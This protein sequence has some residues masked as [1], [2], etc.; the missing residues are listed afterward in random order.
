MKQETPKVAPSET[1]LPKWDGPLYAANTSHHRRYDEWF[2]EGTPLE[3]SWRVLDLGCGSGDFTRV[4]ADLV[5]RGHVVGI[6]PQRSLLDEAEHRAGP[7]QSFAQGTAQ[8]LADTLPRDA[9]FHL[10]FS[11]A[12]FHWI[13]ARDHAAILAEVRRRLVPHGCFRLE[14][15]G[16]GNIPAMVPFLDEISVR[17]QGATSPWYFPDAGAYL[18]LLEEAGFTL[19]HGHARTVAQRRA[20]DEA[21]LRGWLESQAL[22]AYEHGMPPSNRAEFRREALARVGELRRRDGT[23]DL[24]YVRLDALAFAR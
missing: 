22:Q 16:A 11:R 19:E 4:V 1:W 6:D 15:G 2:L 20:F 10:V 18:D 9:T 17:H 21:G 8:S 14:M 7:N 24:T 23:F 3:P 13:P 12:V 5:P